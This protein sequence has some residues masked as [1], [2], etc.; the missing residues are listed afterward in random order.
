VL[1]AATDWCGRGV[2]PDHASA[3]VQAIS[4]SRCGSREGFNRRAC[5]RA[6]PGNLPGCT[7]QPADEGGREEGQQAATA[8]ACTGG[9]HAALIKP[10]EMAFAPQVMVGMHE[11]VHS[12]VAAAIAQPR[13]L[14]GGS[15][16]SKAELLLGANCHD[17]GTYQVKSHPAESAPAA[18]P[19]GAAVAAAAA[20]C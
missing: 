4:D 8:A 1:A 12:R 14:C 20:G 18:L 7:S 13:Q 6:S 16:H 15:W 19:T 17:M 11:S 10:K 2:P 3:A 5:P 9:G